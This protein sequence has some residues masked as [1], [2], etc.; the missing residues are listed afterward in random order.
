VSER[1]RRITPMVAGIVAGV[2]IAVIVA[3][4]AKINLD[5]AAP[6]SSTHT[7]AMQ[8]SDAD[9]ISVSSDVR[10][11]G[12]LVGQVTDVTSNGGYS[13]VTFHVDDADWPLPSDTT[14]SI[15]LAT[16][17]GQKY[18][19]LQPGSD[20]KNHLADSATIELPRTKPVVDFDQIL[21]TFDSPTRTS[22]TDIIKTVGG[23]VNGQ[24]GTLQQLLPSL[25]DLSTHSVT[26]TGELVKRDPEFNSILVNLGTTADQ[27]NTS[28]NDLAGVI[29]NLNSVTGALAKNSDALRGFIRNADAWNQT[30]DAVLGNGGAEQ[31]AAGLS[32]L[33]SL[34]NHVNNT[35]TA[36]IPQS[37]LFS[38]ATIYNG[39]KPIDS[40]IDLI[41][42]ISDAAS[43]GDP[44]G[45]WLRQNVTSVDFSGLAPTVPGGATS[46]SQGSKNN[47]GGTGISPIPLPPLPLPLPQLPGLPP[48]G[49]SSGTGTNGGGILPAPNPSPSPLINPG[50]IQLLSYGDPWLADYGAWG[51]A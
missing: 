47:G 46:Q 22:L 14:A 44:S 19:E 23:A 27:L 40:A 17:L 9:G 11:A 7:V 41:Y 45:Q 28:R 38:N 13:T 2:V 8:V 35:F 15:R 25:N 39:K 4:M 10:I 6:W 20:G 42:E 1:G 3:I 36:L 37:Y 48:V 50:G 43:Q 24:E 30:T 31:F 21:S 34:A 33:D 51:D 26:P 32:R 5:F 18:V 29:D 49:G 12:R 16:L